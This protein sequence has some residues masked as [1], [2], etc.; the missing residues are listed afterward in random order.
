MTRVVEKMK[1]GK[2]R[3]KQRKPIEKLRIEDRLSYPGPI[4]S[5]GAVITQ[6]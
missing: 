3:A 2:G 4:E 6:S 5:I 1:E